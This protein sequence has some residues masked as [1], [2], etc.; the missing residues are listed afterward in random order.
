MPKTTFKITYDE[1]KMLM[2]EAVKSANHHNVP[3]AIAIVD[4][5][6]H[7]LLLESLD[8]TM[9]SASKIAIGKA[10]TAAAFKRPTMDIEK[11]VLEGRTP[12]LVLD[13]VT[14]ESYVPLKGGYPIWYEG[15]LV[16]A[17]A[18]AGTMDAEMDEVVVLEALKNKTW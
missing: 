7:L 15:K 17:I 3:G 12:M 13:S 16:G 2:N 1:A 8:N 18:V 10:A 5:G 11:V 9:S 4:E 6:G 14:V